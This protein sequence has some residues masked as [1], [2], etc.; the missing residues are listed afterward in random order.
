[1]ITLEQLLRLELKKI[2]RSVA[3]SNVQK[4]FAKIGLSLLHVPSLVV[5]LQKLLSPRLVTW[6]IGLAMFLRA[7]LFRRS[8]FVPRMLVLKL[9]VLTGENLSLVLLAVVVQSPKLV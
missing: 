5:V 2:I 8:E 7:T 4:S 6:S 3:Q 9:F 1:L